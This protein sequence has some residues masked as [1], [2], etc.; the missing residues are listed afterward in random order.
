MLTGW[1]NDVDFESLFS[2]QVEGLGNTGDVLM[3]LSTSG[4]SGNV[5]NA[6]KKATS[7]GINSIVMTGKNGGKLASLGNVK[8]KIP[9]DDTQ[10]IQEG[11]LTAGHIFCDLV[12]TAFKPEF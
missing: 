11:H 10:R 3:A 8:I 1:V 6:V 12:E 2:R 9:S 4:N 7:I 5:I